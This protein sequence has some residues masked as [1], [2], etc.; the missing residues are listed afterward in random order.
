MNWAKDYS[1][2]D[3]ASREQLEKQD[4]RSAIDELERNLIT[5]AKFADNSDL[6]MEL[7]TAN[8]GLKSELNGLAERIA[9]LENPPKQD[10]PSIWD[11]LRLR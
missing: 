10:K 1:K 9:K 5:V 11:L 7:K 2:Y 8:T 3:Q 6:I 4:I